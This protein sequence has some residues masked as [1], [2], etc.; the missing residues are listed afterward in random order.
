MKRLTLA[1]AAVAVTSF[2]CEAYARD[3]IRIVGS[4]TV[5]PFSTAVAERFGSKTGMKTPVVEST[6]TGG[7]IKLFC[8]GVGENTADIT[9]ASRRITWVVSWRG[10]TLLRRSAGDVDDGEMNS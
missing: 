6:G 9:N 1:L 2:A 10:T 8:E 3:Q 5:F 7:G 4:S